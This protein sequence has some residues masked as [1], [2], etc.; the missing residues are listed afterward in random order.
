MLFI[1]VRAA[2]GVY[3]YI[4]AYLCLNLLLYLHTCYRSNTRICKHISFADVPFLRD[5]VTINTTVHTS[6]VDKSIKT[7]YFFYERIMKSSTRAQSFKLIWRI[8]WAVQNC[9]G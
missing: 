5:F 4:I 1:T 9:V 6:Y 7:K 3:G 2:T 8:N